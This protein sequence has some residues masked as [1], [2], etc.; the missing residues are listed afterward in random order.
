[1]FVG[2]YLRLL[3][4]V[5]RAQTTCERGLTL[6]LF[7]GDGRGSRLSNCTPQ[8][9]DTLQAAKFP[10]L[11]GKPLDWHVRHSGGIGYLFGESSHE[12]ADLEFSG[13]TDRAPDPSKRV[14]SATWMSCRNFGQSVSRVSSRG[15]ATYRPESWTVCTQLRRSR[16][17]N[18]GHVSGS[19]LVVPLNVSPEA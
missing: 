2:Q 11:A 7:C 8:G 19:A 3:C 16:S 10:F 9:L 18:L 6:M 14:S 13:V 12:C 5:H 15:V 17:A 4:G 1:M